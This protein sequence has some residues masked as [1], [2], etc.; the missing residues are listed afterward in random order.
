MAGDSRLSA[1]FGADTTDFKT[2]I[3][4]LNRE[5]K[6]VESGFRASASA[7]GEW[8]SS[9]SG[10]EMRIGSLTNK[11]GLQ[12]QKVDALRG[13]Y[14]RLAEAH[15]ADSVAAQNAEIAY[16]KSVEALNSMQSELGETQSSL[17]T[18]GES[19]SE[20]GEQAEEMGTKTEQAGNKLAG[21]KAVAE[22]VAAGLKIAVAAIAALAA[23]AVGVGVAIGKLVVDSA[24]Y[25]DELTVMSDQTGIGVERLQELSYV[26][27]QVGVSTETITGSLSRLT[28][29]MATAKDANS[30]TG[31]AF[32][33]LGV[34]V[35][36][37][38]GNLLTSEQVFNAS[39]DALGKIQNPAERDALAMEIFGKSAMELNPLIKAGTAEIAALSQEAR[40]MGAVVGEDTI[41]GL[42]TFSDTLDGMKAGLKGTLTT[43]AGE[44]LPGFQ[45]FADQTKGYLQ[46]FG[47][48]VRG[49]GGDMG[50]LGEGVG[51]LVGKMAGDLA[52]QAPQL[53]QGG[54]AIIK[55]LITGIMTALPQILP[56]ITA[57]LTALVNF[58][59]QS[60]PTL[61]GAAVQIIPPWPM[62]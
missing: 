44:F 54:L 60:L 36:D 29:S 35:T 21:L 48:V 58:L 31:K 4:A 56:A 16:N 45:N 38:N 6:V 3:N 17:E 40:D 22:G 37:V 50:K 42:A 1:R 18:M 43:L 12:Q 8:S 20:T 62:P 7:L 39:I 33:E 49:S 9:A 47:Q 5:M 11:I 52:K 24:R 55:G 19:E 23:A 28:R 14:E 46:E 25:A 13:E 26:A 57:I 53:L 30:T 41:G 15:G 61:V 10:L 51:N 34:S 27:D 2:Q 59:V 32:S